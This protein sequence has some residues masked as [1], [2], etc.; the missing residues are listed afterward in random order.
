MRFPLLPL[1]D[2]VHQALGPIAREAGIHAPEGCATS[3]NSVK[4]SLNYWMMLH[5]LSP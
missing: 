2:S 3:R 5:S 4:A 1:L